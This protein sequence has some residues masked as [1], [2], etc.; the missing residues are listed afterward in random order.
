[1][2]RILIDC[3][4][5]RFN[6][7]PT[8]IPRVTLNYVRYGLAFAR[9]SGIAVMPVELTPDGRFCLRTLPKDERV[10]GSSAAVPRLSVVVI[11]AKI[12]LELFR[13]FVRLTI[14]VL[15]LF[16]ALL[17]FHSLIRATNALSRQLLALR[18]NA[19]AKLDRG[20]KYAAYVNA[21]GG[22]VVLCPSFWH[23]FDP[24]IYEA[25]HARGVEFCFV[26]HD[27]APVTYPAYYA[28]PWRWKFE[29]RLARSLDYVTHYYC[30]SN[31]T[32][33]D[34]T[35]FAAHRQKAIRASV[36][37]NG[38]EPL[39]QLLPASGSRA[40]AALLDRRPWLMVG[41]LEP[42]KGHRDAL[43]AFE[44]LWAA[45]YRRP[46]L[47]VG[48]RGWMYDDIVDTLEASR[49]LGDRLFWLDSVREEELGT[50][51]RRA[52]A[53]L[54]A[55][56][57]EG[58]GLPLIE[59]ASHG[60]PILAR[61]MPT[62]R[63]ILGSHATFFTDAAQLISNVR[64]MEDPAILE[65]ARENIARLAWFDWRSVVDSVMADILRRP[66]DRRTGAYLLD[67]SLMLPVSRAAGQ[68]Q[69][70]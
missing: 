7:R 69:D 45:G 31:K 46:L 61:D 6:G 22:D 4:L 36:A 9:R 66:E 70:I 12:R 23:D 57:A 5:S 53:L 19:R 39:A 68:N 35:D 10:A 51:Y 55:S 2:R 60:L 40:H 64:V 56:Y 18:S 17:P 63:E 30:V 37:Y 34:L 54:F 50:F 27:L 67:R 47:V 32:L 28:Y 14:A 58:F 3:S 25:L 13:Y 65:A 24:E 62:A 16:C 29:Q 59:A 26:L 38:F 11:G 21:G 49:W 43:A 8:G 41:S 1:V 15:A 52:Y 33:L 20:G 42:K 44:A 48:G